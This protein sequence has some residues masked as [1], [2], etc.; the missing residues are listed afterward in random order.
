MGGTWCKGVKSEKALHTAKILKRSDA[1]YFLM[2][3]VLRGLSKYNLE[4]VISRMCANIS[5]VPR[6]LIK[7]VHLMLCSG[8]A[9]L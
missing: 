9:M 4:S 8:S 7:A 3:A 6:I 5:A 1:R 2:D